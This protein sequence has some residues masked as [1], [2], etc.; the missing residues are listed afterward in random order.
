MA[1]ALTEWNWQPS[2]LIGLALLAGLYLGAVYGWRPRFRPAERLTPPQVIWFLAGLGVIFVALLS[3]LDGLG[4]DYLF[5]AHMLQHF[6]IAFVAPPMLLLGA[7]GWLVRP[8]FQLP[9][10]GRVARFFTLPLIAFA[11][12][13]IVFMVWHF[14]G[15][16]EATLHN[17]GLHIFEHLLFMATGVLNW[18]PVLSPVPEAPRLPYPAQMAYLFVEGIPATILSA[19]IVFSPAVIYP[20]YAAAERVIDLSPLNDQLLAGLIMWIPCD[21]IYLLALSLVFRAWFNHEQAVP[22]T[23]S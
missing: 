6:L 2:I 11:S 17:E 18:W 9:G 12:F 22:A 23:A 10:V 4:D 5:S 15:F 13:N 8:L 14:P 3:P 20:T 19:L 16:Y 7:P 1:S 21:M